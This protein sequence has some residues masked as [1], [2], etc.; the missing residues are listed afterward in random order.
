M[1]KLAENKKRNEQAILSA[2]ISLFANK[3]F[4][5]TSISDIVSGSKLARGTFY[6]YFS[7]KEEIWDKFMENFISDINIALIEERKQAEDIDEFLYNTFYSYLQFFSDPLFLDLI[8]RN[9]PIFRKSLFSSHSLKSLYLQ[10]EKDLIDSQYFTGL[11]PNQFKMV[12]YSMVGSAVEL[13]IQANTA[14]QKISPEELSTF[15]K[16]LFWA[17]MKGMLNSSS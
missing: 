13:L 16:D 9:Q 15:F 17:G 5:E 1:G 11:S 6:N 3:G 10:L 2:A 12:S 7:S 8:I 4:E 14:E